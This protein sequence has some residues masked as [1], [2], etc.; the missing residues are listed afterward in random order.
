MR[1]DEPLPSRAAVRPVMTG[2]RMSSMMDRQPGTV[3]EQGV[4]TFKALPQGRSYI[5][6]VASPGFGTANARA[7][8]DQTQTTR[9]TL[10]TIKL[11]AA[12]QRLEGEVVGSDD[13]PVSGVTVRANGAGQ[14]NNT[15][16]T[17]EQGHFALKVCE[18]TVRAMAIPP[19]NGMGGPIATGTVQAQSGDLNVVVKLGQRQAATVTAAAAQ[20]QLAARNAA[21]SAAARM[22]GTVLAQE[23]P[24]PLKAQSWTWAAVWNW[25]QEHRRA[26]VVLLGLQLAAMVG[27]AGGILWM[28]SSLSD[29]GR[30]FFQ[31]I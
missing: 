16:T 27:A 20:A 12:D 6:S 5:L 21:Q 8:A 13:K 3:D 14:P 28:T 26:V 17:D 30:R 24:A 10:P 19:A 25:T 23:R 22:G 29:L 18:G 31:R 2:V 15:T 4:F 11:K 7:G 1:P 9:L